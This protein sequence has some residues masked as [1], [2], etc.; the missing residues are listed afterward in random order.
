MVALPVTVAPEVA[1]GWCYNEKCDVFSFGI[2]MWQIMGLQTKPYGTAHKRNNIQFFTKSVWQGAA[3]RPSMQFKKR[4]P[5]IHFTPQLQE[6]VTLCWS[7]RWQDRPAM[8]AVE[9]TIGD[10]VQ[11]RNR[12]EKTVITSVLEE[13]EE[14]CLRYASPHASPGGT[15]SDVASPSSSSS[16]PSH[17]PLRNLLGRLSRSRPNLY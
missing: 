9:A 4:T 13:K 11:S 3:L 16:S 14:E 10:V 15:S 8:N 2:V 1:L 17:A 7:H 5:H 6:L 12:S